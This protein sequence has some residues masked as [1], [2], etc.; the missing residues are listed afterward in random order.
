[1]LYFG[2]SEANLVSDNGGLGRMELPFVFGYLEGAQWLVVGGVESVGIV[3]RETGFASAELDGAEERTGGY[4]VG[5]AIVVMQCQ[6]GKA[7]AKGTLRVEV[8][9]E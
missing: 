6:D 8:N 7:V 3:E 1:M 4:D 9:V 2:A 5:E